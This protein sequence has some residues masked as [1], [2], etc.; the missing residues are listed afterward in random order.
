MMRSERHDDSGF[1]MIVGQ[2]IEIRSHSSSVSTLT[3]YQ[4]ES[5]PKVVAAGDKTGSF[6]QYI[7]AR[8]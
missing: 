3:T 1:E 6:E 8:G 7:S 4:F 2:L 5:F